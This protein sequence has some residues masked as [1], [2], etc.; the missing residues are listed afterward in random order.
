LIICK[1][2][3]II[4]VIKSRRMRWPGSVAR[5]GKMRQIYRIS[6]G[7]HHFGD[8]VVH[9][10]IILKRIFKKSRVW[11]EFKFLEIG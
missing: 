2:S 3:N 7:W 8:S 6:G 11:T 1:P 5:M 4:R 9:G 10:R